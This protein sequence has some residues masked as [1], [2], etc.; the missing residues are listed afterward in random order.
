MGSKFPIGPTLATAI[1]VAGVNILLA[2]FLAR[3]LFPGRAPTL[4]PEVILADVA[5]AVA[6]GAYAV[7][8][9]RAYLRRRR[10][11]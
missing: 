8:G 4:G 3:V 9:W 5:V 10:G 1:A 7:L 2:F 11:R 6:S